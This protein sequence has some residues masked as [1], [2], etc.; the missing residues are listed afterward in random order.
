MVRAEIE[1]ILEDAAAAAGLDDFGDDWFL[2]PLAAWAEDLAQPNL[3]DFGR[4]FLRSLVVRDVARR[5]AVLEV[6]HRH[7]EIGAIPIPPLLYITGPERSGTTLLHNLLACQPGA[8]ALLRWE[9]M[10]PVPPPETESHRHD[11]RIAAVQARVEKLRGSLL[12]R[13]HWV[14]ADEPE[15]CA[16]GFIDAVSMLGQVG[17]AMCMPQWRRFLLEEDLAPAFMHYRKVVQILLWK[18]PVP[19]D[20][21]LVLK[22]PQIATH[23]AAVAWAFPEAHFVVPDRDPYRCVVSAAVAGHAI[24]E[25]FVVENPLDDDGVRQR[26]MLTWIVPKLPAIAAFT[27]ARPDRITHVA[28]PDLISD[29]YATAHDIFAAAGLATDDGLTKAIGVFLD[30]QR[31]GRRATPPAHLPTMGY[32]EDDVRSDP[33][34]AAYCR[35]FAVQPETER[36]TGVHSSR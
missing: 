17:V 7:P 21:C 20:G 12:E 16:W 31:N 23:I 6:L 10:E 13:M 26:L 33:L 24:V 8:R 11:P 3:N 4:R 5:L 36:L 27:A 34:V 14:N 35:R 9:L 18:N 29:P 15:E 25:P 30:A 32:T 1:A 2:G 19:P 28:Y 22:A